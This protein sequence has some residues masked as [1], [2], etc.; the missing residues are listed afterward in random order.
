MTV[1]PETAVDR[2]VYLAPTLARRL[3]QQELPNRDLAARD[4]VPRAEH[5]VMLADQLHRDVRRPRHPEEVE[6]DPL[7]LRERHALRVDGVEPVLLD[8]GRAAGE[9]EADRAADRREADAARSDHG[10]GRRRRLPTVM[11]PTLNPA[12]ISAARAASRVRPTRFGT[13]RKPG[14]GWLDLPAAS[15]ATIEYECVSFGSNGPTVYCVSVGAEVRDGLAV[16]E[17]DEVRDGAA[18][19]GLR[20]VERQVAVVDGRGEFVGVAGGRVSAVSA[21]SERWRVRM[22]TLPPLW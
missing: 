10:A 18:V 2:R 5:L 4:R 11:S 19:V 7:A 21:K 16:D 15:T 13:R 3:R 22:W 12:A 20:P 17:D 6:A 8:V 1:V 14:V 9:L